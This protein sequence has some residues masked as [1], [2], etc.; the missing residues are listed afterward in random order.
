MVAVEVLV[1]VWWVKFI[2]IDRGSLLAVRRMSATFGMGNRFC[3][4][5]ASISL[6]LCPSRVLTVINRSNYN[7]DALTADIVNLRG[8]DSARVDKDVICRREII[9]RSNSISV[10]SRRLIKVDTSRVGTL[11]KGSV[12][13]VFRSPL[14]TLGPLVQVKSRVGRGLS[15]R[16]A[17]SRRRG[18]THMVRLL[19][20]IKVPG[21]R[22]ITGVCPRRLSKKVHRHIVVTVTITYGPSIVVTSRPAATLS[23]AV[24]TRVLSLLHS[25]RRRGR[26]NMVLVARSLNI[27]TRATSHIT[28]VCT[29]RVIRIKSAGRVFRGPGRPCAH[30]L[31]HSVPR[32]SDRG[33]GLCIVSNVIPSL[34]GVPRGKY[35]FTPH[36]S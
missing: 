14:T 7:G 13:V 34:G 17:V 16:A 19:S 23:I 11:H 5:V 33:S 12:N 9:G 29:K 30:S 26:T 2:V 24:R 27:I 3:G 4:T 35:Q 22:H 1:V 28:I 31:L 15:F 32:T 6:S 8:V 36:I 21:P 10:G 20:R 25:V 18:R